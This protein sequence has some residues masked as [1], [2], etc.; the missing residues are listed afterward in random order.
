[1]GLTSF[2]QRHPGSNTHRPTVGPEHYAPVGAALVWIMERSLGGD[3][4]DEVSS[5]WFA[6]Y[7]ALS[8]L[9]IDAALSRST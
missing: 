7:D 4:T 6:V 1:M 8:N 9:M 3:F 2:D 5:A